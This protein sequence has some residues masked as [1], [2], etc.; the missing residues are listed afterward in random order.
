MA[1]WGGHGPHQGAVTARERISLQLLP[2]GHCDAFEIIFI[3][4]PPSILASG[5]TSLALVMT[6][7]R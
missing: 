2:Y 6:R 5:G 4:F 7:D 1:R 3:P